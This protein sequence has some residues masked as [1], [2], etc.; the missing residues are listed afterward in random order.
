[1][2]KSILIALAL[3]ILSFHTTS[4]AQNIRMGPPIVE[5]MTTPAS[6][7]TFYISLVNQTETDL[8][9]TLHIKSMDMT[10]Q[11][12]PIP[13]DSASRSAAPWLTINDDAVFTL[14]G[15]ETRRIRCSFKP[16]FDTKPGGYYGMIL[17]RA[18]QP[19]QMQIN[20]KAAGGSL[21]IKFQFASVVLAVVRGAKVQAKIEPEAPTIF[22]GNR[23]GKLDERNWYVQVPARNDG[24]IHVVLEG[25]AK[26]FS[27]S[28]QLIHQKGLVSGRG[29]LLP[30]QRRVFKAEGNGPL[31]DGV[32]IA[33]IELGQPRIK[34]FAT[35][36]VPFYVLDGQVYPGSPGD[37]D[38]NIL[39]ATSQGF[40]LDKSNLSSET[41]AG[42]R[43]VQVVA[44]SNISNH[45]I[46]IESKII[47]WDQDESGD[48]IFPAQSK[49]KRELQNYL[50]ISPDTLVLAPG[51]KKIVKLLLQTPKDSKGEYFDAIVFNRKN[52]PLTDL[53]P[54]LQTQAVLVSTKIKTTEEPKS[55][56]VD[57]KVRQIKNKGT[58]FTIVIENTGNIAVYP[59]GNISIFD[60]D[61]AR[62]GD[63]IAFGANTFVLPS[64]KRVYQI[65]WG[66]ILA[67]GKHRAELIINYYQGI[68][69]LKKELTF[70]AQ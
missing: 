40:I 24:N 35:E 20:K 61:N 51:A 9:V 30:E 53:A 39:N 43:R 67:P 29:Y 69:P 64:N 7:V 36:R 63:P 59:E 60:A 12:M 23:Y 41:T 42:G 44:L 45:P 58:E 49:H 66:R 22:G 14:K 15:Y 31:P 19:Q 55:E 68:K 57:F 48:I 1:M 33:N 50:S 11:G 34:Q 38:A 62:V 10:P 46:E 32:Y 8:A 27:E 54:L 17:A 47:A 4:N 21:N 6:T 70:I 65:E 2:K 28:G 3:L 25:T 5:V 26:L 56:L 16:P 18:S 52:I 13:V 37:K